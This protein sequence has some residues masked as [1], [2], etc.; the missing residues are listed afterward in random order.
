MMVDLQYQ[1]IDALRGQ[2]FFNKTDEGVQISRSGGED[3]KSLDG[4]G[5]LGK[6]IG[7]EENQG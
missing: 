4:K 6:Q 7:T 2:F 5:G 3:A 1:G